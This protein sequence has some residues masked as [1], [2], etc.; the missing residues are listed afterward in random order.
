MP[1]VSSRSL[2]PQGIPC[3][4]PRYLPAAISWSAWRACSSAQFA[5]QRDDAAQFGIESLQP[6]EI[7]LREP[8]RGQFALLNPARQPGH[9]RERDLLIIFRKGS[10]VDA[11]T[12]EAVAIRACRVAGQD[13]VPTGPGR[14]GRFQSDLA[15]TRPAFIQR[16]HGN[17]PVARRERAVRCPQI[18]LDQL[19][20]FRKS[21]W[22]DLGTHGRRGAE[23]R[24]RACG[25]LA[26]R[27]FL[28]A[29]RG[30][31]A[32]HADRCSGQEAPA[33]FRHGSS[34]ELSPATLRR[35]RPVS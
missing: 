30:G 23:R 22:R 33:R 12:E 1:A 5:R 2:A 14:Q 10:A 13:R 19:P 4:G 6:V 27:R 15:R 16:T 32:Q 11:A 21:G 25:K 9:W 20:G 17:A 24:R 29:A 7:N 8:P 34:Q 3:S 28:D 31:S 35:L 26:R 18:H